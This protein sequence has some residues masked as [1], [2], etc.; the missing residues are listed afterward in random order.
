M[1]DCDC[2]VKMER[3]GPVPGHAAGGVSG[4]DELLTEIRMINRLGFHRHIA[5]MLGVV[6]VKSGHRL[7]YAI[8]LLD[9]SLGSL[10]ATVK[11]DLVNSTKSSSRA[12]RVFPPIG[13]MLSISQQICDT[14]VG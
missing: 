6:F 12:D 5:T 7:G 2:V 10:I 4:C 13:A 3:A 14:M 11:T 8:E 1:H 9:Q